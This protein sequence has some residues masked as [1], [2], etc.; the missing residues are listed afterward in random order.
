VDSKFTSEHKD[1]YKRVLDTQLEIIEAL[2]PGKTRREINK[3]TESLL[4]K[5]LQAMN[6]I[7][8][9]SDLSKYYMHGFGHPLG[10]DVHDVMSDGIIRSGNVYTVEPGIYAEEKG[11]GIRIEDNILIQESGNINLS[12]QIPKSIEDVEALRA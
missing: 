4:T 12:A 9:P 1:V 8:D 11:F 6:Y 7:S 5:H 3:L 10:L 2:R